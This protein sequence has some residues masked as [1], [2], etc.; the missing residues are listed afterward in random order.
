MKM[1]GHNRLDCGHEAE[2]IDE[3]VLG[4]INIDDRREV[5]ERLQSCDICRK[6][7]TAR[8]KTWQDV[9]SVDG[10]KPS[11]EL[12]NRTIQAVEVASKKPQPVFER[13][14]P[15]LLLAAAA[16]AISFSLG[17]ATSS[18]MLQQQEA[19]SPAITAENSE[20]TGV[21]RSRDDGNWIRLLTRPETTE[22]E[23]IRPETPWDHLP[24]PIDN[25]LRGR[26][27][28]SEI[29]NTSYNPD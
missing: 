21:A 25:L 5:E 26:K 11:E 23:M 12:I 1:S 20:N 7:W 13:A 29:K 19:A 17:V 3:Y 18:F 28:A 14:M 6:F 15:K 10:A 4:D 9:L 27:A 22:S 24:L 2:I 16:M 8:R